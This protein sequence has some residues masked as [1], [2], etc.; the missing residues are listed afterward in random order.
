MWRALAP[1]LAVCACT[2]PKP[3]VDPPAEVVEDVAPPAR[4]APATSCATAELACPSTTAT[5]DGA[6]APSCCEA[7]WVPGGAFKFG[8]SMDEVPQPDDLPAERRER[9]ARVGGFFLD[10]FEVTVGR[11]LRFAAEYSPG[12]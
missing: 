5:S 11:F 2:L 12:L 8:F 3:D 7:R 6:A 4:F 10:R 9:D 1:T